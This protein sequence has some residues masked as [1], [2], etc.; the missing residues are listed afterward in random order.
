MEIG[1]IERSLINM[2]ESFDYGKY[3]VDLF[4][5]HHTGDFLKYIPSKVNVLPEMGEYTV[6]RKSISTCLQERQYSLSMVRILSKAWANIKSKRMKLTEGSG[7]IQMQLVLK[8]SIPL[9][10]KLTKKYDVAISYAWPHDIVANN[11]DAK[12]KIAWVHTDYSK[13]EIDNKRDFR[14][15]SKFDHIASVSENCRNAF[16][17]KYP[18]LKK[19][20][21]VIENITSP[22]MI[23]TLANEKVENPLNQDSR[24]KVVTVARLSHAK[25]ID[26]AVL[27][28]KQLKDKGFDNIAWYVVGYGGEEQGIRN[29]I[30]KNNLGSSFILLGKKVNPYPYM[31]A[32]DL[33]VQPSRYE[34]KA[35]TVTEAQILGKPVLIT[36]YPTA[37]SQ[38]NNGVD[39]IIC[40]LSVDG[41]A[42]GVERFYDSKLLMERLAS[43]C[44]KSNYF[45]G[46]KE[47][48]KLDTL[49]TAN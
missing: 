47:L 35:V 16:L 10:A 45:N 13:L 49:F 39:G 46:A 43:N 33:Y 29:L 17:E 30:E 34:G 19:K 48:G 27:A 2:L 11:V 40:E 42:D 25:G 22:E 36:N 23:Q 3:E 41:I 6:F 31:K 37:K 32:A 38:V 15:W 24:F 28:L 9:I 44:G 21:I 20:T 18:L 5:C 1:G 26:Q 4:I 7:Y 12:K 14:V 8:Y